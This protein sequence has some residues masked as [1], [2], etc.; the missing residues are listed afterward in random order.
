M[1]EFV[2]VP[3]TIPGDYAMHM[4]GDAMAP[5][6]K[7]HDLLVVCEAVTADAGRIVVATIDGKATVRRYF[8][9]D[10]CPGRVRLAADNA[11]VEAIVAD[12]DQVEV[13]GVVTGLI[14]GL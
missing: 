5:E 10:E 9:D 11:T 13:R 4:R 2:N 14:R 8:P 3:G 7:D 12:S 1:A 6:I